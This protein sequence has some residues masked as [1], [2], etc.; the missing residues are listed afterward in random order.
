[1]LSHNPPLMVQYGKARTATTLQFM[2]LCAASCLKYGPST[3]C[4]FVKAKSQTPASQKC[5]GWTEG[6]PPLVCKS[7]KLTMPRTATATTVTATNLSAE[8]AATKKRR[9]ARP[10]RGGAG[11]MEAVPIPF[12]GS[13]RQLFAT[14]TDPDYTAERGW[15]PAARTLEIENGLKAGQVKFMA[16]TDVIGRKNDPLLLNEYAKPEVLD[17]SRKQVAALEAFLEPWDKLRVC[18]GAQMSAAYRA[19]LYNLTLSKEKMKVRFKYRSDQ[20]KASDMCESY[21]VDAVE[22]ELVATE[23]YKICGAHIE[24]IRKLSSSDQPFDGAYC[25]RSLEAAVKHTFAFND[26]RYTLPGDW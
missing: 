2:T 7:H 21:D 3:E 11:T 13:G 22:Q 5:L 17:L 6:D 8:P 15:Q 16:L 26:K 24:L 18:C 4:L 23:V 19:R 14:G 20:P 25:S 12:G 1:M 10:G 9:R